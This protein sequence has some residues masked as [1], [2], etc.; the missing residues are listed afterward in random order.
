MIN[1]TFTATVLV[2]TR[3]MRQLDSRVAATMNSRYPHVDASARGWVELE[4]IVRASDMTEA[5]SKAVTMAR[6][7]SGANPLSCK[8]TS[9]D[10]E[11]SELNGSARRHGRHAASGER[12]LRPSGLA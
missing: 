12:V 8:V 3:A 5:T 10:D 1:G 6:T 7:V 2:R 9:H 11:T 4:F